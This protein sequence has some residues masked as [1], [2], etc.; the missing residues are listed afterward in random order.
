MYREACNGFL[1][2]TIYWVESISGLCF[3]NGCLFFDHLSFYLLFHVFMHFLQDFTLESVEGNKNIQNQTVFHAK[4]EAANFGACAYH[5][6]LLPF[7]NCLK[8]WISIK[9]LIWIF[10]PKIWQRKIHSSMYL[11]FENVASFA[12]IALF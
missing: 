7:K 5:L 10:A 9:R 6:I 3:Y 12:R 4:L 1:A 11:N 2:R 8:K